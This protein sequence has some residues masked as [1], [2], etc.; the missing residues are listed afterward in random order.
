[1]VVVISTVATGCWPRPGCWRGVPRVRS[2]TPTRRGSSGTVTGVLGAW[3]TCWGLGHQ[4]PGQ[5][6]RG[7]EHRIM[8]RLQRVPG[9]VE[10]LG[11]APLMGF[12]GIDTARA[13][14]HR[15][16]PGLL[17]KRVQL[18]GRF[19]GR[20]GM[21]GVARERPGLERWREVGKQPLCGIRWGGPCRQGRRLTGR[22]PLDDASHLLPRQQGQGIDEH[23]PARP[24]AG[25]HKTTTGQF[26]APASRP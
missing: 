11:R 20:T 15:G 23:Q 5:R 4:E 18:H 19:Q 7:T 8:P 1:M 3:R 2:S 22:R 17:P 24:P 13:A 12:R 6:L 16:G 14:D 25:L 26:P 9:R 10:A 21:E